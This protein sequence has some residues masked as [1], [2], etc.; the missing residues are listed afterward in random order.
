MGKHISNKLVDAST[1]EQA[2]LMDDHLNLATL[3]SRDFD[4]LSP[5]VLTPT[6]IMGDISNSIHACGPPS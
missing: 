3:N 2:L 6:F 1:P 5:P 4:H